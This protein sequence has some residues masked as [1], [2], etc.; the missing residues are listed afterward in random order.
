MHAR[1]P[2]RSFFTPQPNMVGLLDI[3]PSHVRY[4]PSPAVGGGCVGSIESPRQLL[5]ENEHSFAFPA[6]STQL[7]VPLG[8]HGTA[9]SYIR[10]WDE[11][12]T[13]CQ[14]QSSC[15]WFLFTAAAPEPSLCSV[16]VDIGPEGWTPTQQSLELSPF[17]RPF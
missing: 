9:I 12:G 15:C 16:L 17:L 5:A 14:C 6:G 8:L 11:P 13:Y 10:V 4:V 3:L 1:F 2:K 7:A